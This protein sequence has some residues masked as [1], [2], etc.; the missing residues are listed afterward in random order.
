MKAKAKP[1]PVCLHLERGVIDRAL[2]IGQAPRSIVRR[3]A[4]LSRRAV[5]RHRD[6]CLKL[7]EDAA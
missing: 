6:V 1:C 4:G 3:Y 7:G 5:Q 2:G